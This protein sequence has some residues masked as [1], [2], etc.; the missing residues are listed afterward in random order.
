MTILVT[1]AAGFIG[2]FVCKQLLENGH[3]V[4]GIDNINDYYSI[5]LKYSRL[6]KLGI[7]KFDVENAGL[8]CFSMANPNF[9]FYKVDLI[10][11][12]N[13][14]DLF[15]KYSFDKVCHL[16]AQAGVRYS[17]ENPSVYIQSNLIG[18]FNILEAVRHAGID[19][20][21]Y[22]SSS[23][24]YG[25]SKDIPFCT[26]QCVERP[27]SLYAATKKSNE[28]MAH[29]YS[30]LFDFATTGLRF[31]TVYGPLGRPDMA[32][33]RFAEAIIN[34]EPIKVYNSGSLSRDFT[35]IDDIVEGILKIISE[36]IKE[37]DKYKIYNIGNSR[38]EKLVD[39]IEI[40]EKY[41]GKKAKRELLPMQPGDVTQTYADISDLI[42][43]YGYSPK[44][45]INEGL[46]K[47][48]QWYK[49]YKKLE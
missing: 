26:N 35:Y 13:I 14:D 36:P 15:K 21:I 45:T 48:I 18:F 11:K 5:E 23:S 34:D 28:L 46:Y 12:I 33:F 44:T 7:L 31:F 43:D 1:G 42:I 30:H 38:P 40:I 32:Y 25:E 37:R 39:F 47:F 41:L 49:A 24:V 3:K 29:T 20:L 17:I 4:V 16:A 27:I 22:A 6:S 2:H 10:D 19:H 9:I 8:P